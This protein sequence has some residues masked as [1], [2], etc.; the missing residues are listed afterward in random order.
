[1]CPCKFS[2]FNTEKKLYKWFKYYM[3]Q[4]VL[5]YA[6]E[7]AICKQTKYGFHFFRKFT[8]ALVTICPQI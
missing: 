1:M 6:V 8:A 3:K 7:A 5:K 4:N 2:V